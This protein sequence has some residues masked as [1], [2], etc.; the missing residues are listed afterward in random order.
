MNIDNHVIVAG[1]GVT[2]LYSAIGAAKAGFEVT[3]LEKY[4]RVGSRATIFNLAPTVADSLARLDSFGTELVDGLQPIVRRS[5]DDTINGM[6][7]IENVG[8]TINADGSRP[9]TSHAVVDGYTGYDSRAWS[10]IQIGG[11]ENHLRSYIERHY[12][13]IDMRFDT[14]I[15]ALEQSDRGVRALT[16]HAATNTTQVFDGAWLV[17]ATG[18]RNIVGSQRQLFPEVAHWVGG[19]METVDPSR[20]ELRRVFRDGADL[21]PETRSL[22]PANSGWATVGLPGTGRLEL[23]DGLI[24]AQIAHDARHV[25]NDALRAVIRD[26]AD[27]LGM[28][29]VAMREGDD[30]LLKVNVQL[31]LLHDQ[32]AVRGRVLLAGDELLGPYFPTSTGGT[33][34]MGVSGPLVEETLNN[35]RGATSFYERSFALDHYDHTARSEAAKIMEVSRGEMLEDLG[36]PRLTWDENLRRLGPAGPGRGNAA[37]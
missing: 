30:A 16:N 36:L 23:P 3:L 12:P 4:A 32:P 10:R 37:P 21:A 35:L 7:K 31:S 18:G 8:R 26:R 34:G 9:L 17:S 5:S 13:Q 28:G 2:G 15:A 29:D 25:P 24:W 27:L 1:G 19:R 11:V 14:T 20:V 6:F 22:N 33:H